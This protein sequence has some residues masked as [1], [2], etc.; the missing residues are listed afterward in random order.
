MVSLITLTFIAILGLFGFLQDVPREQL[1][2]E[3][4]IP[5]AL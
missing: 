2:L 5:T 3:L 4:V 1:S